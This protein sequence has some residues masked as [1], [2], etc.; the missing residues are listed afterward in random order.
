MPMWGGSGKARP[1]LVINT[2]E[3]TRAKRDDDRLNRGKLLKKGP[4]PSDQ[5]RPSTSDMRETFI[6][7]IKASL[8]DLGEAHVQMMNTRRI[9]AEHIEAINRIASELQDLASSANFRTLG[10]AAASLTRLTQHASKGAAHPNLIKLHLDSLRTM[11]NKAFKGE[12]DES[13]LQLLEALKLAVNN[14]MAT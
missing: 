11:A 2:M 9:K 8:R 14:A 6:R 12:D 7:A 5:E 3:F 4:D 13:T 10:R 1:I